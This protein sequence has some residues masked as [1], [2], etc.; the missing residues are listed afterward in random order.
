MLDRVVLALVRP[1]GTQLAAGRGVE[2]LGL[3]MTWLAHAGPQACGAGAGPG[4]LVLSGPGGT[5]A[6]GARR[7][8]V[9][10]AAVRGM[11]V[12]AVAAG[13]AAGHLVPVRA[14]DV[15][16]A[17]DCALALDRARDLARQLRGAHSWAEDFANQVNAGVVDASGA[18]LSGLDLADVGEP[19]PG[20]LYEV[21]TSILASKA[22]MLYSVQLMS[23]MGPFKAPSLLGDSAVISIVRNCCVGSTPVVIVTVADPEWPTTNVPPVARS[24]VWPGPTHQHS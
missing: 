15:D 12:H 4:G 22:Q 21:G 2:Q 10:L 6:R 9:V 20:N 8:N 7:I 3:F 5:P 16:R 19:M 23:S 13:E 1:D 14:L 18:D 11:V 24:L 17:F